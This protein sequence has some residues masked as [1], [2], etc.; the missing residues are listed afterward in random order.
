MAT[1]VLFIEI[2]FREYLLIKFQFVELLKGW[3]VGV[4]D[5]DSLMVLPGMEEW[6]C[7]YIP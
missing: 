2:A 3:N 7:C 5:L 1:S 6:I 4:G